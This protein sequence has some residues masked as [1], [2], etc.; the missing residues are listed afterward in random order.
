MLAEVIK[1][2]IT[3]L[4]QVWVGMIKNKFRSGDLTT[5]SGTITP[6]TDKELSVREAALQTN[7]ANKFTVNR[8]KCKGKCNS[9]LCSCVKSNIN[10]TNHCHPG[11]I[12]ENTCK[13]L[14]GK[15]EPKLHS[16]DITTLKSPLGWLTDNHM[17]L[18]NYVLKKEYP[19]AEGLQDTLLQ[20]NLSWDVP[21]GEFVQIL[22]TEGNHWITIS[23]I[24]VSDTPGFS[25]N[26]VNVYDSLYKGISQETKSLIG[27]YHQGNKVKINIMNVQQQEND[28][29]CGVFAIAFAKTILAGIDPTMEY[30]T[31]ARSHLISSL[32][33]GSIPKFPSVPAKREPQIL[34]RTTHYKLKPVVRTGKEYKLDILSQ[35]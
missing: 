14:S 13:R 32:I 31:N 25:A 15:K 19:Y 2:N 9:G 34:E 6:N 33:Q 5:F 18:A 17:F 24:N 4:Q 21:T 3:K 35:F 1:S 16:K 28:S 22:H 10:C 7:A 23:N 20:Q 8:C 29:D 12:C 11:R 26:T 27:E 30:F